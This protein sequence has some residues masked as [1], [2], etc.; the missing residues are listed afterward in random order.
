ML[1]LEEQNK[2]NPE[3]KLKWIEA[4]RSG[5]YKQGMDKL[6]GNSGEF[7]CLGVL[8]D[9]HAAATDGEWGTVI[10]EDFEYDGQ[11]TSLPK[12]VIQWAGLPEDIDSNGPVVIAKDGRPT[13][14]FILNDRG[15]TF[16][17]IADLIEANL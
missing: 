8:C 10:W 9:L 15:I 4:L 14:L 2:M 11:T 12:S 1:R 7:C 5:K 16:P 3:I 17:Q 13:S 6:H